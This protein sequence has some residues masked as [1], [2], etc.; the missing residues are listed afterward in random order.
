M[1]GSTQGT[2]DHKARYHHVG[3]NNESWRFCGFDWA[4]EYYVF[5]V[6]PVLT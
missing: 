6:I 4:G 5:T 1:E 3:L 2:I